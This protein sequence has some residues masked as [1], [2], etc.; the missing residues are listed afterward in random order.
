VRYISNKYGI[1]IQ[2]RDNS[3]RFEHKSVRPFYKGKSILEI[4]YERMSI[5]FQ[6]PI[7]VATTENSPRTIGICKMLNANWFVG[8]ETN[9]AMRLY[10]TAF[11]NGF[12]GFFRVC[13]DN[14]FV[15]LPLMYPLQAWVE[16]DYDYI[17]FRNCMR[18]HEGFWVEYIKTEALGRAIDMIR[19][20]TDLEHV[21]PYIIRNPDIF[22]QMILPIPPQLEQFTV[23]LT[24]DTASDFYIAKKVYEDMKDKYWGYILEYV[25]ENP[26]LKEKMKKNRMENRK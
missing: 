13:A 25:E 7:V 24:V 9:V 1:I 4:I 15:S 20:W 10:M 18:R 23:R 6:F 14:P 17:A 22:K 11:E 8:N 19:G 2:C 3:T 21:T 5:L 26:K 12:D 16:G